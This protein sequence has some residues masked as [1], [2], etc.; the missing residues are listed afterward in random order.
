MTPTLAISQPLLDQIHEHALKAYPHE[1][2]GVL[3][4]YRSEGNSVVERIVSSQNITE[5]DPGTSYQVDWNVLLETTKATRAGD[6]E[7]VGFYHS[8]PSGP[9]TPSRRD[10]ADAWEGYS[11]LI[12]SMVDGR[13]NSNASWR[14]SDDAEGFTVEELLIQ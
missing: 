11:Y 4:G 2:C 6:A 7:I 9:A 13:A 12:V 1:C 10:R 3:V 5:D 8:H 14:S